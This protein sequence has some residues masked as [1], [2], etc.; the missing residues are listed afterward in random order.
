MEAGGRVARGADWAGG[1][2]R[3]GGRAQTQL[4]ELGERDAGHGHGA[5]VRGV[6]QV[7]EE[8]GV[9]RGGELL[10]LGVD[11]LAAAGQGAG[12]D[13]AAGAEGV[14]LQTGS[15]AAHVSY[16]HQPGFSLFCLNI[17]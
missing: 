7:V 11:R 3:P 17:S 4:L 15:R 13:V 2:P 9:G 8:A 1:E 10:Q 5:G 6:R 12:G 16:S 14:L